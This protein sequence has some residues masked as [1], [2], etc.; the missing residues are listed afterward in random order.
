VVVGPESSD[1]LTGYQAEAKALAES[2]RELADRIDHELLGSGRPFRPEQTSISPER[3]RDLVGL[4]LA[5]SE[6]LRE[7][8]SAPGDPAFTPD[9]A[10]NEFVTT[11]PLAFLFAVIADYQI[12]AERAWALPWELKKRLGHLDP[13]LMLDGPMS[14]YEAFDR[15]PKLHR[16]I[17]NVPNFLLEACRVVLSDY[18]GDAGRIWADEPT[19]R[20]LQDRFVRFPGISQKKAAMA[21]EILERDLGVPVREM[22]GSD[23][24]FDVHVR[25]VMLRTGLAWIDDQQHMIDRARLLHATRPGALDSPMWLIGRTWCH[26]GAPDCDA[27]VLFEACPKLIDAAS[28][29]KGM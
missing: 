29:V 19:A 17:R 7:V 22:E 3:E 6:S 18:E 8:A 11:D 24:A 28:G 23:L 21:V 15:P 12:T 10:A 9:P 2:L 1:P 20:E 5:H 26:P 4:L 27:C 14:L 13:Q 16:F 25:R